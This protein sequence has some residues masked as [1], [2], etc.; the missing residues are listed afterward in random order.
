M[1]RGHMEAGVHGALRVV[2]VYGLV[3]LSAAVRLVAVPAA[4]LKRAMC[5]L[6]AAPRMAPGFTVN[7]VTTLQHV[8]LARAHETP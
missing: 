1:V 3:P 6:H 8:A 4:L 5:E 2:L 7:G